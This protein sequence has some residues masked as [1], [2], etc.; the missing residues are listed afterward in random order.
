MI[1]FP[2]SKGHLYLC[3]SPKAEPGGWDIIPAPQSHSC[4]MVLQPLITKPLSLKPLCCYYFPTV[5]IYWPSGDSVSTISTLGLNSIF[6]PLP[7][8]A[9]FHQCPFQLLG[10]VVQL[11]QRHPGHCPNCSFKIANSET[12]FSVHNV[13]LLTAGAA[14]LLWNLLLCPQHDSWVLTPLYCL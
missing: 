10:P 7:T 4:S 14:I 2:F 1:L 13:L 12:C 6:S 3:Y 5:S 9:I 8:T 11:Q